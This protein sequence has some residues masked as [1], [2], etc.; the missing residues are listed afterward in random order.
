MIAAGLVLLAAEP[1]TAKGGLQAMQHFAALVLSLEYVYSRAVSK[2]TE[3][4][5][6]VSLLSHRFA[7][8]WT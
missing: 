2:G 7:D 1:A 6:I 3:Y 8:V 4:Q 5:K